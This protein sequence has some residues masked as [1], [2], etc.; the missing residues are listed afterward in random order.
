MGYQN[1]TDFMQSLQNMTENAQGKINDI[2]DA[3]QDLREI[4]RT[5]RQMD[6]ELTLEIMSHR[7]QHGA[8]AM[9]GGM[10]GNP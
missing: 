8:N 3:I 2:K 9:G 5:I 1:V 4:G 7:G 10:G 6:R